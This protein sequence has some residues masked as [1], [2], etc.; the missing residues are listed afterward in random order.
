MAP[1]M[2]MLVIQ[3]CTGT[4]HGTTVGL[5]LGLSILPGFWEALGISCRLGLAKYSCAGN[6]AY[7]RLALV[8]C[9]NIVICQGNARPFTPAQLLVSLVCPH[10]CGN[11]LISSLSLDTDWRLALTRSFSH[12]LVPTFFCRTGT[13]MHRDLTHSS[14]YLLFHR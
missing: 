9:Q 11:D 4:P 7:W 13:V 10:T 6:S 12:S 8:G 2:T 5:R 3:G 14:L 1:W